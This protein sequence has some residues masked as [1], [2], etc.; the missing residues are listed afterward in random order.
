VA[1][2]PAVSANAVYHPKTFTHLPDTVAYFRSLGV[3]QI[4]INPDYSASWTAADAEALP[5]LIDRIA[6]IYIESYL[7]DNP[8]FI[9]VID[10]KI[11]VILRGGYHEKEHCR[12]GRGEYAFSP[13]GNIYPCERLVGDGANG[14]HRIGTID[15][16]LE[17]D[18]ML[19]HM[20]PGGEVNTPCLSCDLRAYCMNWCG[21]SNFMSSGHYNRVGPFT[22]ASEKANI[23]A[24]FK[25]FEKLEEALGPTFYNHLVCHG[26]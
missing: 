10:F 19:C 12:M 6:D 13:E 18:K 4:Y 23:R 2:L 5:E 22:C 20:A 15:N 1:K 3:R 8:V 7:D 16:G 17:L 11:A 14:D 26:E 24:A 25:A 21:C 9:N